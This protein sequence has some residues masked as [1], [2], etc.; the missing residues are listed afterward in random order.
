MSWSLLETSIPLPPCKVTNVWQYLLPAAVLTGVDGVV[1]ELEKRGIIKRTHSPYNFL[2]WPLKKPT[3]QWRFTVDYRQL[4]ASTA[5][6]TAAVP[7]IA[8]IVTMIQ[9]AAHPWTATLD[10]K[11]MFFMIPL[12]E[13]HKVRFAFTWKGTQC[14]FNRLLQGYKYSPTIAH[15][16]LAKVLAERFLFHL[17]TQYISTLMMSW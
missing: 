11:D 13:Q 2:T 9:G 7:S 6:L 10:V 8:K 1:I 16:T 17:I 12:P 5:P 15:N 4:N 3:M 14:T